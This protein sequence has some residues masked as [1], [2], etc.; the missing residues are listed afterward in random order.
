MIAS[1]NASIRPRERQTIWTGDIARLALAAV[2]LL[3]GQ[4]KRSGASI[5]DPR[6]RP[7]VV[8][9][10]APLYGMISVVAQVIPR[11]AAMRLIRTDDAPAYLSFM[12]QGIVANGFLFTVTIPR[13][14]KTLKIPLTFEEQAD[15]AFRNMEAVL[16]AGG[17][18]WDR[19]VKLAVYLGDIGNW[20]KMNDVYKR[21]INLDNPPVRV[22]IQVAGLNNDYMIEL[23]AIALA[24]EE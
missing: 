5:V 22:T 16:K 13:D 1:L 14:A 11:P 20:S 9:S 3:I 17:S 24:S 18:G 21:Y 7:R 8:L 6:N 2:S 4:N 19:L 23:D 10:R 12:A 15:V